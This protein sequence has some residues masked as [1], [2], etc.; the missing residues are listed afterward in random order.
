[1]QYLGIDWGYRWAAFCALSEGGAISGEGLSRR[2]GASGPGAEIRRVQ[3]VVS[4]VGHT[5]VQ[6]RV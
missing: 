3:R 2:R 6:G 1:V 4:L 5:W